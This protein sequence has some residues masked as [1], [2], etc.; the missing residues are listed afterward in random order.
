MKD[1]CE[2]KKVFKRWAQSAGRRVNEPPVLSFGTL[3]YED[4]KINLE[5]RTKLQF[6]PG[7][8]TPLQQQERNLQGTVQEQPCRLM[9]SQRGS[10]REGHS[11]GVI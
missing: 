2:R 7:E 6:D 10:M 3:Q 9:R 1:P 11:L 4:G 5:C 8:A